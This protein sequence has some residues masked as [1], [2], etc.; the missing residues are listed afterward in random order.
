MVWDDEAAEPETDGDV[1]GA[2]GRCTLTFGFGRGDK[3]LVPCE[4]DEACARTVLVA[5]GV[6]SPKCMV[7]C[8]S[9]N[10]V[11]G[12]YSLDTTLRMFEDGDDSDRPGG[13]TVADGQHTP[14]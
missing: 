4:G 5:T 2:G 14:Q 8:V 7:R 11:R 13:S 6:V 1:D 9:S 10:I 12:S 3:P